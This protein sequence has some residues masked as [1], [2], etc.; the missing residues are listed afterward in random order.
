MTYPMLRVLNEVI[1]LRKSKK[2]RSRQIQLSGILMSFCIN[3]FNSLKGGIN[4]SILSPFDGQAYEII[5]ND[6]T[7]VN[8]S[9]RDDTNDEDVESVI[10]DLLKKIS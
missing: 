6:F 1:A 10:Y 2:I 4:E 5:Y 7:I 9:Y 8:R 3:D